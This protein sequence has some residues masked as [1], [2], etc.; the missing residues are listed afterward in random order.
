MASTINRFVFKPLNEI[1][2]RLAQFQT[3]DTFTIILYVLNSFFF[4]FSIRNINWIFMF[5]AAFLFEH[6]QVIHLDYI[7]N[8]IW[9]KIDRSHTN[10][11]FFY[12]Y[13]VYVTTHG[14]ETFKFSLNIFEQSRMAWVCFDF[15]HKYILKACAF[16]FIC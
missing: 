14:S 4:F 5:L 11:S 16:T 15:T 6:V 12:E 2:M 9:T 13:M 3:K 7:L 10:I 8:T 1:I